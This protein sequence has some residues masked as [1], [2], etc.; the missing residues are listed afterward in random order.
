MEMEIN[1]NH[2]IW[3]FCAYDKK[4]EKPLYKWINDNII[5]K[6]YDNIVNS[7]LLIDKDGNCFYEKNKKWISIK[8]WKKCL[9]KLYDK[10]LNCKKSL[11]YC[12][13]SNEFLL[14][15]VEHYWLSHHDFS[16]C[17]KDYHF[18]II[19]FDTCFVSCITT[20]GLYKNCKYIIGFTFYQPGKL[21]MADVNNFWKQ[22]NLYDSKNNI[23]N[24]FLFWSE[25]WT[26]K[27]NFDLPISIIL[28][29]S[30]NVQNLLHKISK[31]YDKLEFH[32]NAGV[33]TRRFWFGHNIEL[34][35]KHS[36]KKS[37]QKKKR[38]RLLKMLKKSI[39]AN[40][41][42]K[43]YSYRLKKTE[44]VIYQHL[45]R[46]APKKVLFKQPWYYR[47]KKTQ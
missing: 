14:G 38:I 45:P 27:N 2:W 12:G 22:N 15:T 40:I 13:H 47:F 30:S 24:W 43:G 6:K 36:F 20:L 32:P 33:S 25:Q 18:E 1:L 37:I 19:L 28:Y 8:D 16:E 21:F 23:I 44:M 26:L 4:E 42:R 39:V 11:Y 7:V 41:Y 9:G 17:L 10:Y 31:N 46:C 3:I 34:V 29:S 5:Y 35:I